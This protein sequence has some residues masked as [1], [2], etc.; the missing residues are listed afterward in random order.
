LKKRVL[1]VIKVFAIWVLLIFVLGEIGVRFFVEFPIQYTDEKTTCYRFDEKLGWFPL[2]GAN[3]VHS[4][5][6][7]TKISN[8][9]DGFRDIDHSKDSNRKSIAFLGDSFVWG[10]DVAAEKRLTSRIQN[11]LPNW[12]IYNMG[13][14]GYGTDQEY[15]LL[16]QWFPKYK[17]DIVYVVVHSNDSIDNRRNYNYN[18]YKPYFVKENNELILKGIPVDRCF[19]YQQ[20]NYPILFKSK[21]IQSL[22]LLYNKLFKDEPIEVPD[23]RLDL[24]AAMRDYVESNGAEFRI[25]FTYDEGDA[26]EKAFLEKE[27][28]SYSYLPTKHKFNGYGNHWNE[29][30]HE[31]VAF[32]ILEQLFK[33]GLISEN[34]IDKHPAN[35]N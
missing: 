8:N 34:D 33:D 10:Y 2:E 12:N 35:E 6:F 1:K 32:K 13:V 16:K 25:V 20:V 21:F 24:L 26:R 11:F 31:H 7:E 22:A 5:M 3:A 19:R 17:P 28:M 29:K 15:L 9:K 14:S 27:Q 23:L 18:Y 4:A 30:G